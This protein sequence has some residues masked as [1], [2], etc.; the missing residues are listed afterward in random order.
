[1]T[2]SRIDRSTSRIKQATSRM[3]RVSFSYRLRIVGQAE[4]SAVSPV[5]RGLHN[6]DTENVAKFTYTGLYFYSQHCLSSCRYP[7]TPGNGVMMTTSR[8]DRSTSRI[9]QATSRMVRVSFSYRLRI[10]GQAE[11]SAVSPVNRGLHNDDTENVAKFTY[12]GLYFLR[13]NH[14]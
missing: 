6:D 5:N 10:V 3:V 11:K 9:K 7:T 14:G 13:V 4:K 2:T 8:I 12:T 1:M